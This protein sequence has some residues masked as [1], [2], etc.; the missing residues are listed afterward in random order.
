[1]SGDSQQPIPD[2]TTRRVEVADLLD[3]EHPDIL[4]D[5]LGRS[6]I[7]S[8]QMIDQPE[9]R[10]DVTIV[11]GRPGCAV[12]PHQ[13]LSELGLAVHRSL[14]RTDRGFCCS[15]YILAQAGRILRR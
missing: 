8:D 7:A 5:L 13:S 3:G 2:F 12:A 15:Y 11:C 6:P 14:P 10:P 4:I 1:M 9:D